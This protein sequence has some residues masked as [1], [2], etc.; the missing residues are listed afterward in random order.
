VAR[1]DTDG[2]VLDPTTETES[3][4]KSKSKPGIFVALPPE[5]IQAV[6]DRGEA[7]NKPNGRV[8]AECVAQ[9]FQYD[10]PPVER[11]RKGSTKDNTGLSAKAKNAAV[12]KLIELADAGQI[13]LTPDLKAL[14]GR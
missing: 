8:V 10:L 6:T 13:E 7:E 4:P 11:L 9:L 5:L 12:L 1:S 3:K 14:L 2:A